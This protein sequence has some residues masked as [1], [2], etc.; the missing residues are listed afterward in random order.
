V[1]TLADLAA[2]CDAGALAPPGGASASQLAAAVRAL[3]LF[4]GAASVKRL[5]RDMALLSCLGLA[6]ADDFTNVMVTGN[7]GTGKTELIGL[8]GEILLALYHG[9]RAR[10]T[11]LTRAQLV[12]QHLGETALKTARAL[13]SAAPGVIVLDE[14]YALGNGEGRD[15]FAKECVDTLNQFM[16]ECRELVSVVVA[17]YKRETEECFLH[18]NPGLARR[19]PHRFHVDDYTTDEL[20][21]IAER[22]LERAGWV[23]FEGWSKGEA[24]RAAVARSKHNGGDTARLLS[25][26]KLAHARRIPAEAELR[27]L[28]VED[29]RAGCA[30]FAVCAEPKSE[31]AAYMYS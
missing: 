14:V 26:C 1:H 11:W 17:G 8:V 22:Q 13:A 2:A 6:D 31:P 5:V 25:L 29:V 16:S 7:P 27:S 30:D 15:S 21:A 24:F 19:F 4:V 3:D 20:C 23:A 10:V 12:G 28:T 9:K 18:Q